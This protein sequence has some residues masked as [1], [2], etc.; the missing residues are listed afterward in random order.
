MKILPVFNQNINN[1]SIPVHN[2]KQNQYN[3]RMPA[4]LQY[5]TVSFKSLNKDKIESL[6]NL[7]VCHNLNKEEVS[8]SNLDKYMQL[9]DEFGEKLSKIQYDAEL[10]C[11]NFYTNSNEE[12]LK[13]YTKSQE[14]YSNLFKDE[15]FY[16]EL[17]TV[18]SAGLDDK[19]LSKQLK[20]LVKAFYNELESGNELKALRDKENE[21][22]SKYN[23]YV[24]TIDGKPVSK[25]EIMKILEK[26]T[27]EDLRK[28]AYEANVKAGDVIA[29]DLV[30]LVKMRNAYARTKGYDNYFDYM[31]EDTYEI[32]PDKLDKL[33]TGVYDKIKDK[34]FEYEKERQEHLAKSFGILPE[35][36]MDYHFKYLPADNPEKAVNDYIKDR[37][38]V[39]ELAKSTYKNMGYDVDNMGITLDLFPRKNKNTHGFAFC[40]E[41]GKDA[42]ILAN[43]TN[44][45]ESLDTI[46]HE[47]GHCVYDICLDTTLPFIEQGPSSAAMTEAVAMMMGDLPKS[48]N[49][50]TGTIPEEVLKK[51]KDELKK[52]DA[53]FVSRSLQIIEFE[54]EM[55]KNPDQD[56]KALWKNMKQKYLF[57]GDNTYVNNEWATVPHYLS[58]PGYYQNY[59]RAALY[60]AQL[61]NTL[62][63]NLGNITENPQT[64]EFL[65]KNLFRYGA[66]LEDDELI[67]KITGKPISEDDFCNRIVE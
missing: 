37:E 7:K 48:E 31:I 32:S 65:N 55:Y 33:L 1:F 61:Y 3:Y 46:M 60:K 14:D 21:I 16:S 9:R 26:E 49:I 45:I 6:E 42:R 28:K 40:I 2:R 5:D 35:D 22:A 57:R 18:Q 36:L 10:A 25:A 17:K 19:H 12:N 23:A 67:E 56:L 29:E 4:Q 54:R 64:A 15:N 39:V 66:S 43:L 47:L 52:D 63:D 11:W 30:D 53:K 58:H 34:S 51:F 41:P 62:K 50:L 44:N 59:F 13:I 8:M 24:M 38:Q 27:N 20:D